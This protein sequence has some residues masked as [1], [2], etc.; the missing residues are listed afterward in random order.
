MQLPTYSCEAASMD[1]FIKFWAN[2]MSA[3]EREGEKLYL[4]HIGKPLTSEN[5]KALFEWK[6]KM[7]LSGR[8]LETVK[9]NF[10]DRLKELR[11]LPHTTEP[12]AFLDQFKE[13]GVIWRIFLL[14]CWSKAKR[15]IYDQHV[16]RAM[17]FICAKQREE[18]AEWKDQK[19]IIDTYAE[20]YIPFFEKFS[21]H[22]YRKVDQ[23]LWFFGRFL[24]TTRFPDVLSRGYGRSD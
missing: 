1:Q 11:N 14:H 10:I 7:I 20:R 3:K 21:A 22:P 17:T 6:N 19:K 13:G 4:S 24:K 15:P 23:A 9:V 2:Q 16:H 8:K 5:L 12:K 18:I